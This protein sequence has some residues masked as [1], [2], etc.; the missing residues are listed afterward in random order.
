QKP[1]LFDKAVHV[2]WKQW[3]TKNNHAFY[4]DCMT[5]SCTASDPIPRFYIALIDESVIGT[6]ALIRND[7]NSRQDLHPWLAC[8]YV[9][10]MHRGK[11]I[12]SLLLEHAI[13]E[14]AK[15]GFEKLYLTSDLE[16]YYEKYGWEHT[17]N[18]Y[19]IS[20]G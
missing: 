8:L 12:G 20:G 2:F 7:L 10:Q 11:A 6:Y 14:T 3:G 17:T 19:G 9:D 16:N 15:K 1:H 4:K 5:H 13:K 18:A